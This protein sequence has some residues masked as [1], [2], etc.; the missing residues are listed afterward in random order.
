MPLGSSSYH[1]LFH[2]YLATVDVDPDSPTFSQVIARLYLP[3]VAEK[4]QRTRWNEDQS[5]LVVPATG[6]DRI[7]WVD[8]ETEPRQPGLDK[9]TTRDCQTETEGEN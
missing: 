3:Y 5:R 1:S 6:S 9:V 4:I 8:V 2:C 7:Y